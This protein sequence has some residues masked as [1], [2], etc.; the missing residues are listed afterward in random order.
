M[1]KCLHLIS[2]YVC[3]VILL[4]NIDD[5]NMNQKLYLRV[6]NMGK[7]KQTLNISSDDA[8]AKICPGTALASG[9]F[10]GAVAERFSVS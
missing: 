1:L 5:D 8:P 2:C 7:L 10:I 9:I 4:W 6:L 3:F